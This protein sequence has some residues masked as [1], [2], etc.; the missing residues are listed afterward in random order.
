M[1]EKILKQ[2]NEIMSNKIIVTII[3]VLLFGTGELGI[4]NHITNAEIT[5]D[6]SNI[7]TELL[8]HTAK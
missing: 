1:S 8:E 2:I 6:S 5:T 7:S 4:N 3:L